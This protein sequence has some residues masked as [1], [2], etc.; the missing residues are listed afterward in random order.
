M[1]WNQVPFTG[2]SSTSLKAQVRMTLMPAAEMLAI[3]LLMSSCVLSEGSQYALVP[4]NVNGLPRGAININKYRTCKRKLGL[5]NRTYSPFLMNLPFST[6]TK[7]VSQRLVVL[8]V[9]VGVSALALA[10]AV[11]MSAETAS[12]QSDEGRIALGMQQGGR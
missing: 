12:D 10:L 4:R 5:R 1:S 2:I 9:G 8:V 7:P 11:A 6:L 3:V